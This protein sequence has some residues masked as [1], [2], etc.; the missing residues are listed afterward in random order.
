M[1]KNNFGSF[2]K[3]GDVA[4][5][6]SPADRRKMK[7]MLDEMV[8][9]MRRAADERESMKEIGKEIKRLY[10]VPPK[11]SNRIARTMYKHDFLEQDADHES[12]VAMYEQLTGTSRDDD[13]TGSVD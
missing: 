10:E 4:L 2:F 6:S 8:G 3:K 11:Q 1:I 12:F 13:G 5:P 7:E 9:C